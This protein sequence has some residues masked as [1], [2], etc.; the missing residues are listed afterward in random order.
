MNQT[1]RLR[2]RTWAINASISPLLAAALGCVPTLSYAGMLCERGPIVAMQMRSGGVGA[3]LISTDAGP[4]VGTSKKLIDG[5]YYSEIE[6]GGNDVRW[7]DRLA[8]LRLAYALQTP[9]LIRANDG[10]DCIGSTDEFS[11]DLCPAEKRCE[12]K[13]D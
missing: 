6:V 2:C 7:R 4:G 1:V 5:K 13:V 11:I 3:V 8:V 12:T 9:V 10:S